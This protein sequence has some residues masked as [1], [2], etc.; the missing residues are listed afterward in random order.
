M[1]IFVCQ[2]SFSQ[3]EAAIFAPFV[4]QL[5]AE[6]Q[7]RDV[8]LKW[9][10][11]PNA[12]G[13]AYVY[14]SN[15][16]FYGSGQTGQS[17]AVEVPYGRQTYTDTPPAKGEWYYY[18]AA[19]DDTKQR[20]DILIPF[21]N[22]VNINVDGQPH[23]TGA[24][25]FVLPQ[26]APGDVINIRYM[27]SPSLPLT[28]AESLDED[29]RSYKQSGD[30]FITG[31][32][33][34]NISAKT[35]GES[36]Q[37]NFNKFNNAKNAVLYRSIQPFRKFSDL[38]SAAV[39]KLNVV[40]P[41]TD[42]PASGV[43]YFYAVVYEEDIKTGNVK[44]MP[45]KNVTDFP[46]EIPRRQLQNPQVETTYYGGPLSAPAMNEPASSYT[47]TD[48]YK[49]VEETRNS[50][51]SS[52]MSSKS[53][54][55]D[56]FIVKKEV[57]LRQPRVFNQDLQSAVSSEDEKNLAMIVQGPF[58]WRDWNMAQNS[59][60]QYLQ[61]NIRNAACRVRAGFYLAQTYY[62]T[63]DTAAAI[64][65]FKSIQTRYPE[66]I[67]AWIDACNARLGYR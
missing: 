4:S 60:K 52:N 7:G 67:D 27:S 1:A 30:S 25:A 22:M 44:I 26:S 48:S 51:I 62:F 43:P 49:A 47:R 58:M 38:L 40:S 32:E 39:V 19:S 46:V 33:I 10:D 41:Y 42:R 17:G 20:Y 14:R 34:T 2:N 3:N 63:G 56:P 23:A 66:E 45:G 21:N 6:A 29:Y 61:S 59:L 50:I 55:P 64:N 36:I 57:E 15:T 18:V 31:S 65:E 54:E 13:H 35:Y 8:H 24:S 28:D 9:K 53:V 11:S 16:P 37:I 12:F 5:Q